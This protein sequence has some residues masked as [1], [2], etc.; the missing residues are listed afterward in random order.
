MSAWTWAGFWKDDP[1]F[2]YSGEDF[3]QSGRHKAEERF[4]KNYIHDNGGYISKHRLSSVPEKEEKTA[5][6][7]NTG[8]DTV[9]EK[10]E[11]PDTEEEERRIEEYE[12]KKLELE[13]LWD[14]IRTKGKRRKK[15]DNEEKKETRREEEEER[16]SNMTCASCSRCL[17]INGLLDRPLPPTP[18]SPDAEV[19][20][21]KERWSSRVV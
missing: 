1:V 13:Q 9:D 19:N 15:R 11:D 18:K 17:T 21:G 4:W 12:R 7:E 10:V 16:L 8:V 14:R 20:S 5:C 6:P 2:R 3:F